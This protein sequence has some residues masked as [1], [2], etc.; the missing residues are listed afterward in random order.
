MVPLL[1][2]RGCPVFRDD[3]TPVSE[4]CVSPLSSRAGFVIGC[5]AAAAHDAA[6][7]LVAPTSYLLRYTLLSR[8]LPGNPGSFLL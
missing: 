7:L 5:P 6:W 3:A 8:H 2:K 4:V 1:L